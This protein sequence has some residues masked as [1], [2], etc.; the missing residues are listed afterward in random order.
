MFVSFVLRQLT[1]PDTQERVKAVRTLSRA[2]AEGMLGSEE[3]AMVEKGLLL[4]TRDKSP[5]VRLAMAETLG[6]SE[7]APE[8]VVHFLSRDSD[9]IACVVVE[10]SPL[11]SDAEL[12]LL[13][14]SS[15][16]PVCLAMAKREVVSP[17]VASALIANAS[18][19]TALTLLQNMGAAILKEDVF[20]IAKQHGHDAAL[21]D[22]L[23]SRDDLPL[24]LR[25][26]LL[27]CTITALSQSPLLTQT[28][29][30]KKIDALMID[31]FERS[32][33]LLMR[34]ADN[35][36]LVDYIMILR[37]G[38]LL[39]PQFFVR[40]VC[41]GQVRFM[42]E[43]LAQLSNQKPHRVYHILSKGN[44][45]ALVALLSR[46][47]LPE[48]CQ[49]AVR[50]AI[51]LLRELGQTRISDPA[52]FAH[53]LSSRLAAAYAEQA[54]GKQA[55]DAGSDR[56]AAILRRFAAEYSRDDLSAQRFPYRERI[57]SAA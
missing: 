45:G 46:T 14:E 27:L 37:K 42:N 32:A 2:F 52:E 56:L 35:Q 48:E 4:A 23:M 29:S 7:L 19:R 54:R 3:R 28:L 33:M 21:R 50:L 47:G 11:I 43:V 16:E 53:C 22:F 44:K 26:E 1:D 36:E 25:H 41:Q 20:L 17:H 39:T 57:G 49:L 24:V 5:D 30:A 34:H 38:G 40:A 55:S 13:A 9:H 18:A 31:A 12:I 8:E 15:D 6:H 10:K 51:G